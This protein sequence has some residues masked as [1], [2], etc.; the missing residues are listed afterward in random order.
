MQHG[1]LRQGWFVFARIIRR[2][3]PLFLRLFTTVRD[4]CESLT[5]RSSQLI[6][7]LTAYGKALT[8]PIPDDFQVTRSGSSHVELIGDGRRNWRMSDTLLGSLF[9]WESPTTGEI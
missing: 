3:Y 4:R 9:T 2:V 1:W 5:D 8:E 7:R 6:E